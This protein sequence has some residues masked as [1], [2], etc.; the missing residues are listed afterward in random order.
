MESTSKHDIFF[1]MSRHLCRCVGVEKL[2]LTDEN[3]GEGNNNSPIETGDT[4]EG[5]GMHR[6][7]ESYLLYRLFVH[8][9]LQVLVYLLSSRVAR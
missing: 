4:L 9:L 6:K 7:T 8:S 3:G 5:H 2:L 1:W